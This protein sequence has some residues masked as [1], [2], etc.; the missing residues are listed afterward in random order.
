MDFFLL[1][2]FDNMP[3]EGLTKW[4]ERPLLD[5]HKHYNTEKCPPVEWIDVEFVELNAFN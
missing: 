1:R 5:K 3:C 2:S 4:M